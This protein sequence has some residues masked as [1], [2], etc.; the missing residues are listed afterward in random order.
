MCRRKFLVRG[1]DKSGLKYWKNS[2][3]KQFKE[4]DAD[5]T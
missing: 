5:G 3:G 4:I 1:G 2:S